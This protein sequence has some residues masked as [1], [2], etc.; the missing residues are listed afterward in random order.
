MTVMMNA[1]LFIEWLSVGNRIST[2]FQ[3]LMRSSSVLTLYKGGAGSIARNKNHVP[4]G[5]LI[6]NLPWSSGKGICLL[7]WKVRKE[8]HRLSAPS[9][10]AG[11]AHLREW[12]APS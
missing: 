1:G 4:D 11:K 7:R 9:D 8:L 3:K 5:K 10:E 6:E 2:I 12:E